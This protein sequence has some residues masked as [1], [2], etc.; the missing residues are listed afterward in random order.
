MGSLSRGKIL[1]HPI[2][3]QGQGCFKLLYVNDNVSPCCNCTEIEVLQELNG[4]FCGN[5]LTDSLRD[6]DR[7]RK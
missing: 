1:T 6:K 7:D 5:L 3:T 2:C 4:T